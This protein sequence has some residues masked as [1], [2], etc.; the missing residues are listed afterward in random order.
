ME[1]PLAA[2]VSFGQEHFGQAP[3]GNQARVKRLVRTADAIMAH[4]EGSLPDKLHDP[5]AYQ[6]LM[7]LVRHKTLTHQATLHTHRERTLEQAR[8]H[9]GVVLFVHDSTEL[10]YTGKKSL[11]DLGQIGKGTRRGYICHNSL[12]VGA[13][14]GEVLGLANQILHRRADVPK[15]ETEAAKRERESRES[16]LWVHARDAIGP[17][18]TQST[19]VDVC[20][21]GADTFEFLDSEVVAGRQFVIRSH[22]DRA[23]TV[24][25]A[26]DGVP[27]RLHGHARSL[28]E[29]GR[30]TVSVGARDGKPAREATVAFSAAPVRVLAPGKKRGKY[31]GVP[32]LLWVVIAREVS[33]PA[34]EEAVE[35]VL[36]TNRPVTSREQVAQTLDWYELRW[37]AEDFHK[38]QKTGCAIESPQF[39]KEERLK[40]M[41]DLLSVIAVTLV[42]LRWHARQPD[43]EAK[44]AQ[45]VLPPV[46]VAVLSIRQYGERQIDWT[47]KKFFLELAKLGGYLPRNKKAQPGWIV[48]WRGWMRLQ[49]LVEF[50]LAAG[51]EKTD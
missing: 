7:R 46:Y 38:A 18:P 39:T 48:L 51:L 15:N 35:W 24:G 11:K 50:A 3:L 45:E 30:R 49:E 10:D 44:P 16:L 5:A 47:V 4:P 33:P 20:D 6:G 31:R 40:P 2:P 12:A 26:E 37:V 25:H 36:L 19:W 41:I 32:L 21:R 17:A 14:T 28:P 8:T 9:T 1:T 29:L 42:N 27:G 23:I 22:H 13:A 43:A 34:G